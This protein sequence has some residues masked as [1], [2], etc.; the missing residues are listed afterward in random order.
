[1]HYNQ[2]EREREHTHQKNPI[3][4]KR[5]KEEEKNIHY[6]LIEKHRVDFKDE[7]RCDCGKVKS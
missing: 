6:I 2:R 3:A 5:K 1:V 7:E 4:Y